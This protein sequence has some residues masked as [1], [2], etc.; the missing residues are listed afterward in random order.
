MPIRN[1]PPA[2]VGGGDGSVSIPGPPGPI[3]PPGPAGVPGGDTVQSTWRWQVGAATTPMPSGRIGADTPAPRQAT[4]LITSCIDGDGTNHHAMLLT[5]RAGDRIHLRVATD[6]DSWHVYDV[7]SEVIDQ[8]SDTYVVPVTTDSGSP[9]N[10]APT[11]PTDVLTAFQ[12][13]PRPGEQGDPGPEG[14]E[15][16]QGPQGDRG[17]AGPQGDPG[18]DGKD[19]KDGSDGPEGPPAPQGGPGEPGPQ[20]E[21]G[22]P[23]EAG[24]EGP[25]GPQGQPGVDGADGVGAPGP[26]GP[27]GDPGPEGATGVQGPPGVQGPEGEQGPEG[28]PGIQG[29]EG[30]QGP[31]GTG[32]PGDQGPAGP[33][34]DPG[35]TGP[36]GPSGPQGIQGLQGDAGPAGAQGVQGPAG[37]AGSTG[38]QGVQGP[39]GDAGIQ[40]PKGDPGAQ[41]PAGIQGTQGPAGTQGPQGDVGPQGPKGDTGTPG[42]TGTTGATGAAGTPGA[43]GP[44]VAAGGAA[45]QILSKKSATD[46]DTQWGANTGG[47]TVVRKSAD[48][49]IANATLQDD[50]HLQLQTVAGTAYEVEV[51]A[52]YA[53]PAGAGT[54]DI[55][56]ELSEDATARGA[57][58]WLGLSTA[59]AAQTL[60]T[61]DVGGT[62]AT[63]GTAAAKR[64]LR[65]LA[66][67]V[68]GG[69]LLKFKWAQ[70]TVTAGSPTVVY[71][72]SVLRYRALT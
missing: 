22:E 6:P 28:P 4:E 36:V 37:V 31:S 53:S 47:W 16:P 29:P 65:A 67:H 58:Q 5:L 35:S 43:T 2:L 14:P 11:V 1:P 52:I 17:P 49:S 8:G 33:Q 60:S 66:V 39:K 63:F 10:T 9:P 7:T 56:C 71:A 32:E 40:G 70:N 26:Q 69:G 15:G 41:G 51:L 20:G 45:G 23:G 18:K 42:A 3:G 61:T 59:D 48:E 44:G 12:F 62:S 50:D 55:K 46:Y 38:A 68:G 21:Q 24:P 19:G 27:Q 57:V 30:Q 25:A 72:G 64:V 34:G 13:E 54:P